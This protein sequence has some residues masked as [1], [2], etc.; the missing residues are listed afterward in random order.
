ML[1][2]AGSMQTGNPVRERSSKEA[3]SDGVYKKF[4]KLQEMIADGKYQEAKAGLTALTAKRLNGFEKAQVEQFLG[5]AESS[6]EN[7]DAAGRHLQKAIDS[8]ALPNQAQFN[9]M[10][11]LAQMYAGG[12]K[13][14]KAIKA[15]EAFYKVTDKIKDTTFYFE[16]S[17][18]A[19]ME[20]YRKS[21]KALNKAIELEDKPHENWHYLRFNLHMQLS[22][23]Q[24]ASKEIEYL[25]ELNPAKKDYWEK[26][27]QVYFTLKKDQKALAAL[28]LADLNGMLV[29]E[30]DR[31]QLYK[32]YAYLGIPYKAGKVL[33]KGLKSG[34]IKPSYKRW[35]D[36]GSIWYSAAEMD[37]A[38]LAFDQASKL[39]KD[40]K[41]DL[42]RAFIYYDKQNWEKAISALKAGIEKGGVKEKKI[43]NAYLLLGMA[44]NELG[45]TNSA[46][47][48][49]KKAM[50]YKSSRGNAQ[51]MVEYLQSEIKRKAKIKEQEKMFA[52]QPQEEES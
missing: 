16:A 4:Q 52:E 37:K 9:M 14:Q 6:L 5:W 49:L 20:K 13:Y 47:A 33:E 1:A 44:Y 10:L 48:A 24:K 27:N 15:L 32:M 28:V 2:F 19:Q 50:N 8:D 43:G 31:L 38:L 39:S 11:Q 26:L 3:M 22:D 30:K 18:N 23:F 21:L 17:L 40:G 36:L 25:I 41:I 51:Q 7:Y 29:K 46:I 34:V 42:R 12:G 45:K 35:D